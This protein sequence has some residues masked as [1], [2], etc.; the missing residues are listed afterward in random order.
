MGTFDPKFQKKNQY[1]LGFS[2]YITKY[3]RPDIS[4]LLS[5][6]MDGTTCGPDAIFIYKKDRLALENDM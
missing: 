4:N 2:L 3:L 1:E 6:W 5:R